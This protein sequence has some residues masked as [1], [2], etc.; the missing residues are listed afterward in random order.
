ML[1]CKHSVYCYRWYLL[2][3]ECC[4]SN[5]AFHHSIY[6]GYLY[7][8]S[9]RCEWLYS[10]SDTCIDRESI[11]NGSD[12]WKQYR[13][14]RCKHSVYCYRWYLLFVECRCTNHTCDYS[15][16]SGNLYSYDNGCE[17]MYS[18]S[19]AYIDGESIANSKPKCS[20]TINM[21]NDKCHLN[22]YCNTRCDVLVERRRTNNC[23]HH[24]IHSRY[25][26]RYGNNSS[27]LYRHSKP[28]NHQHTM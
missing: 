8:Y 28:H 9:N 21:C 10:N 4:W 11:A 26:Y 3:V 18:N 25:I 13:M 19:D 7:S 14:F 23:F 2:F 17:R 5:Y 1:R 24:S 6:G 27:R 22:G 15:I 12:H 20:C 16:Y